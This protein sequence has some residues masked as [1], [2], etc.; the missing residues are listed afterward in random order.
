LLNEYITFNNCELWTLAWSI[1]FWDM[2]QEMVCEKY[3][4]T[5]IL[6]YANM[7]D[8][9]KIFRDHTVRKCVTQ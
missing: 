7:E 5:S 2:Q 6:K 3:T 9:A 8:A 1:P 4:T